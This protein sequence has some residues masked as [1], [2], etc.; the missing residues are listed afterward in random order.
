MSAKRWLAPGLAALCALAVPALAATIVPH[1]GRYDGRTHEDHPR[2]VSFSVSGGHVHDFKFAGAPEFKTAAITSE[3]QFRAVE[4]TSAASY[5]LLGTFTSD[6]AV[7]GTI[8]RYA[9]TSAG[10]RRPAPHVIGYRSEHR[11]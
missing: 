10:H 2:A 4:A 5:H 1:H 6:T 3:Y 11:G 8:T 7:H 9:N